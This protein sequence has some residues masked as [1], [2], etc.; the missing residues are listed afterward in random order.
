MRQDV[1]GKVGGAF[2]DLMNA[3]DE[4]KDE[5]DGTNWIIARDYLARL[6]ANVETLLKDFNERMER[7]AREQERG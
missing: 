5:V 6:E 2:V 3:I 1:F 4:A 7:N